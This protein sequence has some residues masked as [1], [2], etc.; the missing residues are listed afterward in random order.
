MSTIYRFVVRRIQL[1]LKTF[2]KKGKSRV[3]GVGERGRRAKSSVAPFNHILPVFL[4]G[5]LY[6]KVPGIRDPGNK[7][8]GVGSKMRFF[9]CFRFR[10][11]ENFFNSLSQFNKWEIILS[12]IQFCRCFMPTLI[13]S[14]T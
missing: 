8:K 14:F 9:L 12:I 1:F 10:I 13:I 2:L 6:S 3:E 7:S 4:E 11:V 5:G